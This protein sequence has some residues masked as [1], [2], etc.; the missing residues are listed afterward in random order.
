MKIDTE[1]KNKLKSYSWS[2][3]A[4]KI[5]KHLI[6]PEDFCLKV[7]E[8]EKVEL[9]AEF[10]SCSRPTISN[11][12]KK[13][14]PEL[15]SSSGGE[16]YARILSLIEYKK[17]YKCNNIKSF[18][19]MRSRDG[20]ADY[21]CIECGRAH[22]RSTYGKSQKRQREAKR[23]AAKLKRLPSWADTK[24]IEDMY[25]NCPPGYE[26]DHII[27]LQGE[28]VSGLHIATNLQYLSIEE[29]RSKSNKFTPN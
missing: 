1:I 22:D 2:S 7:L 4:I 5:K 15:Y 25:A 28:L 18:T 11:N 10:Y 14:L 26:V 24:A 27:P 21:L 12:I 3:P 16:L 9:V 20:S 19:L 17:C 23:R 29:N 13:Y 6:A 8:L